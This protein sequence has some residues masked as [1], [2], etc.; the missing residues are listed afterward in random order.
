MEKVKSTFGLTGM[1]L[2]DSQIEFVNSLYLLCSTFTDQL[3]EINC[4]E[5]EAKRYMLDE[6]DVEVMES[7]DLARHDESIT[8]QDIL[9]LYKLS[10]LAKAHK[11]LSKENLE[12]VSEV[13]LN[14]GS[15]F[16]E[17]DEMEK[18]IIARCLAPMRRA[19]AEN[20]ENI[21]YLNVPQDRNCVKLAAHYVKK[22]SSLLSLLSQKMDPLVR[23]EIARAA[24]VA[25]QAPTSTAQEAASADWEG[26][27]GVL[28]AG[29]AGE[30]G[31][32]TAVASS[33]KDAGREGSTS[34]FIGSFWPF[35]FTDE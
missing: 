35:S 30:V 13:S 27:V 33:E 14:L 21:K 16:H 11:T 19:I 9:T 28:G 17:K 2:T 25:T 32:G 8:R 18:V 3:R 5:T 22:D 20:K 23:S 12:A 26:V 1:E 6:F 10:L 24:A 29:A 7:F 31:E 34:S 4:L 15:Q